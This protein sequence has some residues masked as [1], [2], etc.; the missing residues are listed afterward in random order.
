MKR[1]AEIFA[2]QTKFSGYLDRDFVIDS[3]PHPLVELVYTIEHGPN[4][5]TQIENGP[6]KHNSHRKG[7]KIC[8]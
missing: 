8:Q 2:K 5:K 7:T 1:S 6:A 4:I 3:A